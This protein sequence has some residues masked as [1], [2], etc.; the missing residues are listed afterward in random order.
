MDR[1]KGLYQTRVMQQSYVNPGGAGPRSIRSTV[2]TMARTILKQAPRTRKQRYYSSREERRWTPP[3]R[4]EE[5]DDQSQ[6]DQRAPAE[7]PEGA[8]PVAL[9]AY[10]EPGEERGKQ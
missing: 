2:R 6:S 8:V 3:E 9:G 5:R 7:A 1:I 10:N 4:Q